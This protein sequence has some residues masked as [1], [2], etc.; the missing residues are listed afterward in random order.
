MINIIYTVL[1]VGAA[2]ILLLIGVDFFE[3]KPGKE[4][5]HLGE[6]GKVLILILSIWSLFWNIIIALT[7]P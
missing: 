7:C 1:F 6:D 5:Y 2:I 3:R 4:R